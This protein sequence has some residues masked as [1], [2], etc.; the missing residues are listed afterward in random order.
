MRDEAKTRA[1]RHASAKMLSF[2]MSIA[3][4]AQGIGIARWITRSITRPVLKTAE[5]MKQIARKISI[6]D[7]IAYQ[8]SLLA[9]NAAIEAARAGEHGF[10]SG[11]DVKLPHRCGAFL[12][13]QC[14]RPPIE[15]GRPMMRRAD[16]G[17]GANFLSACFVTFSP[18]CSL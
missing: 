8:A 17:R 13:V 15:D 10:D 14:F 16:G 1:E 3:A 12:A 4:F 7:D 11:R 2:A 6:I 5:A 9:L 18:P